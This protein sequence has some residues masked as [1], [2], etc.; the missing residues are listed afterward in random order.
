MQ[1]SATTA[2]RP[3]HRTATAFEQYVSGRRGIVEGAVFFLESGDHIEEVL[4]AAEPCDIVIAPIRHPDPRTIAYDGSFLEPGDEITLGGRHTF[5]LQDYVAVPFTTF[6]GPTVVRQFSAAG[7]AAFLSDAD[8]ARNSGVFVGQLLNTEVLLDS[9][10]SSLA[11]DLI[12]DSIGR[13]HV[14]RHGEYRDGPDGLLLGSVGDERAD[15]EATAAAGAGR[16]RSFAGVVDP[17]VLEADLDDRPWFGRYLVALDLMRGWEGAPPRAAISGFGRHLVAVLDEGGAYPSILAADAPFLVTG[18]GEEYILV[19]RVSHRRLRRGV[20]SARAAECLIA[21]S[22][23]FEATALLATELG[24]RVSRVAPLVR[25]L[26]DRFAA[27]GF[28]VTGYRRHGS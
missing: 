24:T 11:A 21:T 17:R 16:G 4:H 23:E 2:S 15:I 27:T 19:D 10:A 25:A 7:I 13:V 14:T 26:Q 12:G 9:W 5:E 1:D 8:T 18:D 6:A 28:D 20:D 22:E 3:S